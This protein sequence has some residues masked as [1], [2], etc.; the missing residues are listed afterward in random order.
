MVG[1]GIGRIPAR[2]QFGPNSV[3]E[4][5]RYAYKLVLKSPIFS[6]TNFHDLSL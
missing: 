4:G 3:K 5:A 1:W 2:I 6:G